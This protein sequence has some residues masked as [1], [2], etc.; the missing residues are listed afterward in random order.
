MPFGEQ[1]P[2]GDIGDPDAMLARF[3]PAPGRVARVVLHPR[4][5]FVPCEPDSFAG[6]AETFEVDVAARICTAADVQAAADDGAPVAERA[7]AY[8]AAIEEVTAARTRR[9]AAADQVDECER[10]LRDA[11]A[12]VDRVAQQRAQADEAIV[13]ARERLALLEGG[14]GAEVELRREL[15][16]AHSAAT[17]A[18]DDVARAIAAA[19]TGRADE[20]RAAEA[21]LARAEQEVE[22]IVQGYDEDG[23]GAV[24]GAAHRLELWAAQRS[25]EGL[26]SDLERLR[27]SSATDDGRDSVALAQRRVDEA[28]ARVATAERSLGARV[29]GIPAGDA[30][31]EADAIRTQIDAVQRS[32]VNAADVR[33]VA[34]AAAERDVEAVRREVAATQRALA[35]L[36][37]RVDPG[38]DTRDLDGVAERLHHRRALL[39][40]ADS[41]S[42]TLRALRRLAEEC[43]EPLLVLVE[44][45]PDPPADL[46]ASMIAISGLK[47]IAFV[48]E[49][50]SVLQRARDLDPAIGAVRQP[51]DT[52][53]VRR[54]AMAQSDGM[55]S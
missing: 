22:R 15:E 44:P 33:N 5:T 43:P 16:A 25:V 29:D 31:A 14:K 26:R 53:G 24:D 27:T 42:P 3:V 11:R 47:R 41:A 30:V 10:K 28:R 18:A 46:L 50:I 36:V 37:E 12:D 7:A 20:I 13:A 38:A 45:F 54:Q 34:L 32:L 8:D 39:D 1:R 17:I 2:A 6:I 52:G 21:A 49:N 23:D 19:T 51:L 48:T 4:L 35:L 55:R 40:T 9:D